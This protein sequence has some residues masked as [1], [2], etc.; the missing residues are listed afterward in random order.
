MKNKHD[1]ELSFATNKK[2]TIKFKIVFIGDQN[3]GK[4]SIIN[5]FI[6][7]EFDISHH[8][9]VGIDFVSKNVIVADKTV[10]LQLWDTAGQERFRS[11]IPGYLRDSNAVFLV[12]DVTSEETYN[13]VM[14]WVDYVKDNRGDNVLIFI[15]GNKI[16]VNEERV[17]KN[18]DAMEKFSE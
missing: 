14:G 11:L 4:S 12:Y 2:N 1:E 5:R 17:I 9:T 16:D 10:R 7:N 3:V 15:I 6:K 8:P 13:N 18:E